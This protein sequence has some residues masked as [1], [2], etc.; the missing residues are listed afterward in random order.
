MIEFILGFET[1]VLLTLGLA[2]AATALARRRATRQAIHQLEASRA[3]AQKAADELVSV[4]QNIA[5][6]S[7]PAARSPVK[8]TDADRAKMAN[9]ASEWILPTA[10]IIPLK[11]EKQNDPQD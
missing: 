3:S 9:L 6:M 4:M 11:K 1:G 8:W 7:Q 5:A 10:E 2:A